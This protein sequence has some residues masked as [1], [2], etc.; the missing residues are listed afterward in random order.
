M[1]QFIIGLIVTGLVAG[2]GF[3]SYELLAVSQRAPAPQEVQ[4]TATPQGGARA[5]RPQPAGALVLEALVVPAQRLQLSLPY[6]NVQ[7]AEV[8]VR[9]GDVVKRGAPLVRL[10]TRS[11]QLSVEDA[12]AALA[13]V[14]ASYDK[15][16]E[17]A[18]PAQLAE[19]QAQLDQAQ[20]QLRQTRSSITP[21]DIAAADAQVA[22]A[23]AR[24]ADLQAG[25]RPA[26]LERGQAAI[27]QAMASLEQQRSELAAAKDTASKRV[28]EA[29]N[30]VRA[31][32]LAFSRAY[33]SYQQTGGAEGGPLADA[34]EQAKLELANVESAL[35][36]ARVLY[37]TAR[38]QEIAGIAL[39]EANVRE[40]RAALAELRAGARPGE[41]ADAKAGLATAQAVRARIGGESRVAAIEGVAAV[42]AQA[43][44]QL[45]QLQSDPTPATIAQ[46]KA[47]I[48]QN[49]VD[50]KRATLA[51]ERATLVAPI[52][53]MVTTLGVA[54]G[55]NVSSGA[56]S[57]TLIDNTSWLLEV[58]A[59][60]DLSVVRIQEGARADLRFFALPG[61]ELT[62]RV[63]R[64]EPASVPASSR[65]GASSEQARYTVV[66]KPDR[67]DARLR[68]NMSAQATI[69]PAQ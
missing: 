32:Q 16:L 52:D 62:G 65:P 14:R 35:D 15:L 30:D 25:A 38:Q 43:Q 68:W 69:S 12:Q 59:V 45:D 64:V 57:V 44:A 36:R 21:Q 63:L 8:L 23:Q 46:V 40:A 11:L 22:Q 33:W 49:E 4:P 9:E 53:G 67:W 31:A 18:T 24:L 7:V 37:E 6:D 19:A 27:D 61:L 17:G 58:H 20:A 41:F 3:G 55:E 2:L 56:A 48:A 50:L 1:R 42:V 26:E 47:Q 5:T 10:D 28:D 13:G 29:A 54:P 60:D 34:L 39:G 51:L 66:I